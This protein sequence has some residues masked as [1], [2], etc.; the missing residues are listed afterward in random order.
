M[1]ALPLKGQEK[2]LVEFDQME[3]SEECG[4]PPEWNSLWKLKVIRI[5]LS[6]L[7]LKIASFRRLGNG[8][9][10]TGFLKIMGEIRSFSG[11]I[12]QVR[13]VFG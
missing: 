7:C 8:I 9:I 5:T 1:M 2:S 3:T 12:Q 13:G 6:A 10:G 11:R 4:N